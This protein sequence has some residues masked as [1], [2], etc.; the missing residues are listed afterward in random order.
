M[1]M[2]PDCLI[3]L[4][5]RFE[6]EL[7]VFDGQVTQHVPLGLDLEHQ[8]QRSLYMQERL[9]HLPRHTI[10]MLNVCRH[11]HLFNIVSMNEETFCSL[12][13]R[14]LWMIYIVSCF[15]V[16]IIRAYTA[17]TNACDCARA[18][19]CVWGWGWAVLLFI[20]YCLCHPMFLSGWRWKSFLLLLD[21]YERYGVVSKLW[22][23]V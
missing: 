8:G 4:I 12:Y 5:L 21:N 18:R 14:F 1:E 7:V 17:V 22:S 15:C 6:Q 13:I 11:Q 20:V 9:C 2:V 19:M 10:M 23:F 3:W 16:S